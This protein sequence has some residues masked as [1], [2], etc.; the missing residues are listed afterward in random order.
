MAGEIPHGPRRGLRQEI[1]RRRER[2]STEPIDEAR[3]SALRQSLVANHDE[4]AGNEAGEGGANRVVLLVAGHFAHRQARNRSVE[5]LGGETI[6]D[7][8]RGELQEL[9]LAGLRRR[10]GAGGFQH[11]LVDVDADDDGAARSAS[12]R[13]AAR[14]AANVENALARRR[15]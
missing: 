3:K 11:A 15:G 8:R 12:Q 6:L 1:G 9:H 13:D 5:T 2:G 14:A 7:L 4:A 10:F